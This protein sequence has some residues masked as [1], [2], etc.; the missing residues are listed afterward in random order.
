MEARYDPKKVEEEVM[1]FWKEN[2][3][4]EK[5]RELGKKRGKA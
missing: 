3:I 2:K 1:K 4:Y 5:V